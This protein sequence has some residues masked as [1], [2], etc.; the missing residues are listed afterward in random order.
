MTPITSTNE[1]SL[2][3]QV[4]AGA[5]TWITVELVEET[6][7]VWQPFYEK[8]LIAEDAL[9]MIIGVSHLVSIIAGT[10]SNETIRSPRQS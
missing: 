1:K 6:V 4:P 7:R 3:L 2:R 10:K 9:E 5:P 8:Q